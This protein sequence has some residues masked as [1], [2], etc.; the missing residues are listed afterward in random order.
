MGAAAA[1]LTSRKR[2]ARRREKRGGRAQPVRR[3]FA[4]RVQPQSR[5]MGCSGRRADRRSPRCVGRSS[6]MTQ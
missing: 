2:R 5:W 3:R 1:P 6:A 4:Q